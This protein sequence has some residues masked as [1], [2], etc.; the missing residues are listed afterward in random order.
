MQKQYRARLGDEE[1]VVETGKLAWQAGGAVTVRVGDTMILVTGTVAKKP[2]EGVDFFPLTVDFEERRYSAGKIP[3]GFF[4]REGRPSTEAIVL[5]RAVDRPLRPLFP[6]GFRNDVQVV[7][8]GLSADLQHELDA[9]AII[10]ASA[11][12]TISDAPFGGP[13][14]ATKIGYVDGQLVINPTIQQL[15]QSQLDLTIAGTEESVLMIEGGANEVAEDLILEAVRLGH[16]AI[17]DVIRMQKQMREE[18]G[19]PKIEAT[20]VGPEPELADRVRALAEGPLTDMVAG[21][22]ARADRQER[23]AEIRERV[24]AELPDDVDVDMAGAAFDEVLKEVMHRHILDTGERIDGRDLDAIRPLQAE[25]G[26]IPRVHGSGL[27]S[28]GETQVLSLITLGTASDEQTVEELSG[29]EASKRF[30]H[31]YNFP[32]YSTGE[33]WPMRGPRRREIG[34]GALVERAIEPL[35]PP[36]DEFP[37]TIRAVSEVLSSNGSTSM[38]STCA[39]SLAL[40]DTGVPMR[41][42][43]AGIAMGVITEGDRFAV[44]TDIQG[45][46]DHLGDMDFK[47]SPPSSWT[48]RSTG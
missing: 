12:L 14:G 45:L 13:V 7:I 10:G 48:S 1:I 32:P 40:M 36:E 20:L 9:I 8:T 35:L 27:F 15:G 43:V 4:R 2:R 18:V 3:G 25:V 28:R 47:A 46:E 39:T 38:A 34:H 11:A 41:S 22:L 33:T 44:L 31:H 29:G 19:K 24:L 21:G 37:Y 6:K 5:C 26:L 16:Q 23:E 42:A 30:M 17:Q